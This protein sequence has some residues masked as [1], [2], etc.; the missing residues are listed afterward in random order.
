MEVR[1][2]VGEEEHVKTHATGDELFEALKAVQWPFIELLVT[3][4]DETKQI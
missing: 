4:V 3:H 2:E 1:A